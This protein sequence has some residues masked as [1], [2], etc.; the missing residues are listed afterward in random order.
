MGQAQVRPTRHLELLRAAAANPEWGTSS[1]TK[2]L[3][4]YH[5]WGEFFHIQVLER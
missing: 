5:E 1:L 2:N 3:S 4:R